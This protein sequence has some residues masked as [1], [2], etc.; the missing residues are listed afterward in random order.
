MNATLLCVALLVPG[1]GEKEILQGIRDAD[2]GIGHKDIGLVVIM[3]ATA[4]DAEVGELC[5]LRQVDTLGLRGGGIT[6]KSLR[7]P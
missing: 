5:E 1:Y 3:P 7:R 2:G 4:T 6:D